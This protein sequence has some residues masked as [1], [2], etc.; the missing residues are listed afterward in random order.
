MNFENFRNAVHERVTNLQKNCGMLYQVEVDKDEMYQHYLDSFPAGSNPMYRER[1]EHD[2]GSCKAFIKSMGNVVGIVNNKIATIWDVEVAGEPEYTHVA[3]SMAAYIRS[4]D[5]CDIWI[6][7]ESKIG[8]K[9]NHEICENG[10][11]NEWSHF[12]TEVDKKFITR[13]TDIGTNMAYFHSSFDVFYR[14]LTELSVDATKTVLELISDNSIYRG[15]E[16]K[17]R[18]EKFLDCQNEFSKLK[19]SEKKLYCWSRVQSCGDITR[20]RNSS[21]GTL[22]IDISNGLDLDSAVRKYEVVVAPANYKRPK[23][24]FT[25]KMLEDAKKTVGELGYMDSLQRRYANLD[26]ITVNNILFCNKDAEKR[27]QSASKS[28]PFDEMANEVALNPKKF[29]RAKEIGIKEFIDDVLPSTKSVEL[30][31]ENRLK[32]NMVSL[33]APVNSE[34]PSMFRWNNPFGWAYS[35]NIADSDVKTNVKNAGGN[36]EGDLRFSIQWNDGDTWDKNDLDAH[37][38]TPNYH[39]FYADKNTRYGSLD[40][41]IINPRHGNAAVENIVFQNRKNM[42]A[43]KYSFFVNCYANRGGR[44][45]FKAE[46]EFDGVIYSYSYNKE[47]KQKENVAVAT[48]TLDKDG[49]FSIEENLD[50]SMSSHEIW[51]ITSNQFVP[52]SVVMYSPNYWD[53]QNG[54]GNKHYFFM[55]K[56]CVNPENPRGFFNEYLKS[57]LDKHKRVFEALGSKM[58]VGETNDQLSGVGF[59]STR[60]NHVIVKVTGHSGTERVLKVVF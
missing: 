5:I 47:V 6:T 35:G 39:I 8:T 38:K 55:L 45:G 48:V 34:A 60:S 36:V 16:W 4:K 10:K 22:L 23:A 51:G 15:A 3:K 11:V 32:P 33:I 13:S 42:P 25:K 59:S 46:I 57:E 9:C 56:G 18:L 27:I 41:D 30:L 58:S 31:F 54:I 14:S 26:D 44:N 19:G 21:M 12:Y 43:G 28:N 53:G 24:I 50:S 20:I 40:V 29:S 7:S 2:C 17:V 37:C 52:V 49:N 1:T